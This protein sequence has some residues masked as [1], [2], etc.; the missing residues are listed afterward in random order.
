MGVGGTKQAGRREDRW[1]GNV[2]SEFIVAG[3]MGPGKMGLQWKSELCPRERQGAGPG[4]EERMSRAH[5]GRARLLAMGLT[6][7][8][9]VPIVITLELL[10]DSL[11]MNCKETPWVGN[12]HPRKST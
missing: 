3:V 4:G 9:S 10:S 5:T 7:S 6:P 2:S 1:L 11:S 12:K 8:L